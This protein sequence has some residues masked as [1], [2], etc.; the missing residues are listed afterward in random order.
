M[1]IDWSAV[2][3][4]TVTFLV[5]LI[6]KTL[7][8]FK[9]AQGFV[10]YFYWLRVRNFFRSRPTTIGGKWEQVWESAN[11]LSFNDRS[12]RHSHPEIRQLGSYCYTEFIAKGITYSVFGRVINDHFVGEWYD[13]KDP[14][15]YYGAFQLQIIDSNTMKGQW[16]GHSKKEYQVKADTWNWNKIG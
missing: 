2:A 5:L 8:D 9:L 16:V 7:F 6:L 14:L 13:K 11:S 1:N 15:G 4:G 10:K 12:D 3:T